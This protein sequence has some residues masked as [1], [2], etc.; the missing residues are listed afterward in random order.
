MPCAPAF[1]EHK[2]NASV[3][4]II[5][6]FRLKMRRKRRKRMN[7]SCGYRLL[8]RMMIL[9]S[10]NCCFCF[11]SMMTRCCSS[12][13]STKVYCF[14]RELSSERRVLK[15]L[16]GYMPRCRFCCCFCFVRM[17]R[18]CCCELWLLCSSGL[19]YCYC[20]L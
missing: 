14:V 13:S 9:R 1:A 3:C 19:R 16:P 12:Y 20:V 4:L 10:C 7:Q 15:I 17:I 18:W 2:H 6:F 11:P 8:R 5:S